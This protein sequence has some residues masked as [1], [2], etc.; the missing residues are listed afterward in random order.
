MRVQ[1]PSGM[2]VNETNHLT[3]F[4]K[5][6]IGTF[7]VDVG[8]VTV[9]EDCPVVVGVLV[10]VACNL[11]LLTSF[12]EKLDMRMKETTAIAGVFDG[13]SGAVRDL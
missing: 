9:C 4:E 8:F 7:E 10:V 13:D 2:R 1:I 3:V 5:S 6:D 12:R 11:L